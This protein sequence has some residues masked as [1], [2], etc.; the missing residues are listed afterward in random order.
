MHQPRPATALK[1]CSARE[2]L[3]EVYL[4]QREVAAVLRLSERTLERHRVSGTGPR[5]VK[6]GRRVVY[7]RHDIEEW[8]AE[9]TLR[10]TSEREV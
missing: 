8:A 4:T 6:L 10:S 1:A 7:R 3:A 2:Y 5:F 9:H